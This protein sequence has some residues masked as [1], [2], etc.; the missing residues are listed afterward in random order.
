MLIQILLQRLLLGLLGA[1]GLI[2]CAGHSIQPGEP[3]AE[4]ASE[5]F[6]DAWRA[7]RRPGFAT[8]AGARAAALES[9]DVAHA[10]Q[11][12]WAA[13]SRFIDEWRHRQALTLPPRHAQ[14]L[15]GMEAGD[16]TAAYLAGRLGGPE[17]AD[18]LRQATR[19]DPANGWAWHG[20]GWI[21]F[22]AGD[23]DAALRAGERAAGLAR[24]PHE[25]ALFSWAHA[26]YLRAAEQSAEAIDV[27]VA[28]LRR[29]GP[30]ALRDEERTYLEAE[31]VTTELES[32]EEE[33]MRREIG[34]AH[35]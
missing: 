10:R 4:G 22:L 12:D 31:L 7:S 19:L 35:V 25:L 28:A 20:L 3:I 1:G 23:V 8:D 29:D 26:R 30:L 16:A 13:P 9:A 33:V 2:A 6:L 17:G 14:H 21:A 24:D 27:L 18:L 11:P 32:D 15:A 34:R 5:A